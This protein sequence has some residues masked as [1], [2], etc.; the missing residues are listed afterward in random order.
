MHHHNEFVVMAGT[1]P[2]MTNCNDSAEL[3]SC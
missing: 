1:N 2:A 3:I